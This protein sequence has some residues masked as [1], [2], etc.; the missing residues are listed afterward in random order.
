VSTCSPQNLLVRY[1]YPVL[2]V[3]DW[4]SGD[5]LTPLARLASVQ[6]DSTVSLWLKL[7]YRLATQLLRDNPALRS[8]LEAA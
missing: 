3:D 6:G 2:T 7:R 1:L 4:R 5:L 8:L